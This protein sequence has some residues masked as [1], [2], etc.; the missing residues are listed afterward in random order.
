MKRF[1]L[2]NENGYEVRETNE[3]HQYGYETKEL[4]MAA[5]IV[6]KEA[7]AYTDSIETVTDGKMGKASKADKDRRERNLKI[8]NGLKKK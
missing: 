7:A 8:L 2:V 4:A 3:H 6:A 1:I 5:L